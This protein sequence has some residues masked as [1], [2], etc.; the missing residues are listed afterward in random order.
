MFTSFLWH[1]RQDPAAVETPLA[2]WEHPYQQKWISHATLLNQVSGH[3]HDA[4]YLWDAL[5]GHSIFVGN[6]TKAPAWAA[7]SESRVHPLHLEAAQTLQQAGIRHCLQSPAHLK[8]TLISVNFLYRTGEHAYAQLLQQ[9]M[10][11]ETDAAGRPLLLLVYLHDVTH[12]KKEQSADLV[13]TGPGQPR[14]WKYDFEHRK[15]AQAKPLSEQEKRVLFYLSQGRDSK[16][17]A[18]LLNISPHTADT[19]RRNLLQ[20]TNCTD[21]TALVTYARMT[22]LA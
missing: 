8:Q 11:V 21:T 2:S 6:R 5:Y 17:L 7:F 4:L 18:A 16:E 20:K 15:P 22:G 3:Q 19:H 9:S 1:Y 13:I 10:V 14:V 12:L